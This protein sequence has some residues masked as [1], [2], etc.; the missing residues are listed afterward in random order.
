MAELDIKEL[1]SAL[2]EPTEAVGN[3]EAEYERKIN[4]LAE[5]IV[6]SQS[7]RVVMLSGPS[8]SGKTTTANLLADR[9]RAMG[10]KSLVVSMDNFYKSSL[11]PT[12]PRLAD[13]SRDY[14]SPAALDTD[15]LLKTLAAIIAGEPFSI[16]RYDFKVGGRVGSESYGSFSDGCVIIEGIHGL[17]PIFSDPFPRQTVLKLFVSVSTN[18]NRGAVRLISGK[19]LRFVRRMVRDNIYR[20]ACAQDTVAMWAN[21][22]DGEEKYLY[23]YKETA[24]IRFDT[25][26]VFE[27]A[28]L[29]PFAMRLLTD[30]LASTSPYVRTVRDAL[31]LIPALPQQI[32]PDSSLI[33]EFIPGGIYESLY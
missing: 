10:E 18:I 14:E 24:D 20:G 28:V 25:F 19:K 30:E 23:P 13:G 17:N 31:A 5:R 2:A 8:G 22:L 33:R 32:V 29:K 6:R 12:Y 27:P 15:E 7:V 4:A 16:P 26:H 9:I 1:I 3:A 11:D 21:V